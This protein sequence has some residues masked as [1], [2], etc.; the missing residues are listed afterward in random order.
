MFTALTTH[1]DYSQHASSMRIEMH[2]YINTLPLRELRG[3]NHP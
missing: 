3:K 2:Y 1:H